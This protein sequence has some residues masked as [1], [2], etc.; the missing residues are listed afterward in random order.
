MFEDFPDTDSAATE[1]KVFEETIE[2]AIAVDDKE[3][4]LVFSVKLQL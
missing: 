4:D 1:G 3:Q 2:D